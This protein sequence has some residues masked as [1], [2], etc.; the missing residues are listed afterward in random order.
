MARKATGKT[1]LGKAKKLLKKA[2]TAEELRQLQSVI[3]PLE[4]GFSM[5]QT[6]AITGVSPSWANKL[7]S[8]FI[9]SGGKFTSKPR[10]GGRRREKLTL[11]EEVTFLSPFFDK[12]KDG[13]ELVIKE[14]KHALDERLGQESALAT[15]YNILHRHGWHKI[16]DDE[17]NQSAEI[18]E[19]QAASGNPARSSWGYYPY[20]KQV[21]IINVDST[22][23]NYALAKV[24]KYYT[25]KGFAIKS[26]PQLVGTIPT[27]VSVIFDFNRDKVLQYVGLPD[28]L[29]GGTGWDVKSRLPDAIEGV[30]PKINLGYTSR[31][32]NR[33]C[34]FCVVPDKE[35]DAAPEADLYDLWD[36]TSKKIT[37][38]DNNILQLPQHFRLVCEQAQKEGILLDW[39]QGLDIRLVDDEVASLLQ[40][41]R[42]EDIR[43]ALDTPA[44]IPL[45]REKLKLLRQFK[46]RK[47]PLI[48]VLVGFDTSWEQDMERIEFLVAEGCRPYIMKHDNVK[49][50]QR[51]TILQEW[52]NQFWPVQ[53]MSFED[54]EKLRKERPD[55]KKAV[56]NAAE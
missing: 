47:D 22:I 13:G 29:I 55:K 1:V 25:S 3:L 32:C 48:Y 51:Y 16:A 18:E 27:Y 45:F 9:K 41:T 19:Q 6:A 37:L 53:S 20:A 43:F 35:G 34:S 21:N 2:Q 5:E 7:R 50:Q 33:R 49:N 30:K 12:V 15:V 54:F 8:Q 11:E 39:N 4:H 42:M 26:E 56:K 23:P 44:L 14:I 36:G 31:G 40:D 28:T 52:C 46:V 24:E 10:R 17:Q 38:L